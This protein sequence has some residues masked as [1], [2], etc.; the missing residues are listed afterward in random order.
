MRHL[1]SENNGNIIYSSNKEWM[2]YYTED[3]TN[4]SEPEN[5]E[6]ISSFA[7]TTGHKKLWKKNAE[8]KW[9]QIGGVNNG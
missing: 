6:S 9:I 8:G 5:Y 1:I 4:G 7:Y 2:I 3:I